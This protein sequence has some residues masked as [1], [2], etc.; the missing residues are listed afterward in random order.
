[1]D[2][3]LSTGLALQ[4]A[5]RLLLETDNRGFVIPDRAMEMVLD[6]FF[7][8]D[9]EWEYDPSDPELIFDD[10]HFEHSKYKFSAEANN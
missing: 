7:W 10:H 2:G 3:Y 6:M 9:Y 4:D 1:M 8:S 5:P